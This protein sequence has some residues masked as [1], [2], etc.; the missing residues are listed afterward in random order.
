MRDLC[1]MCGADV[2]D[3]GTQICDKCNKNTEAFNIGLF[4]SK[5]KCIKNGKWT[6][7]EFR[8]AV[9]NRQIALAY[10]IG[11][12]IHI[13]KNPRYKNCK[14]PVNDSSLIGEITFIEGEDV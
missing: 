1:V 14:I 7:G 3:L 5:R 11:N 8:C 10:K 2:S 13:W 9:C 6:N 12:R 4:H